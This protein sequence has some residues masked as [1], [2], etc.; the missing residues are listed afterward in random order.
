MLLNIYMTCFAIGVI[1]TLVTTFINGLVSAVD[2]FAGI[3]GHVDGNMD[4]GI[5]VDLDGGIDADIDGGMD[6][7]GGLD[8]DADGSLDGGIG[9]QTDMAAGGPHIDLAL[10]VRPFTVMIMITVFGGMGM[11][12]TLIFGRPASGLTG[13][14]LGA[15]T[16]PLS[17]LTAYT[18]A[19]FL[20]DTVYVAL[21]R[22][23]ST[24]TRSEAD[25]IGLQAEVVV[26]ISPQLKGKIS[27]VLNETI[28]SKP[29]APYYSD[30]NGYKQGAKVIIKDIRDHVCLVAGLSEN[31][32]E[33]D[34]EAHN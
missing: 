19:K 6:L 27:Y 18:V 1:Y 17:V 8:I 32:S 4:S 21:V 20:Y 12:L 29:A 13:F 5:D 16:L 26:S 34:P 30:G 31:G 15:V 9:G 11:I 7:D 23:Q 25:A 22:A 10:P 2:L 14:F 28:L 3:D 33:T 24:T